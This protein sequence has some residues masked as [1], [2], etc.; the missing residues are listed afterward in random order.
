[1]LKYLGG[2][3]LVVAAVPASAGPIT[4]D[5]ITTSGNAIFTSVAS[6]GFTFTGGHFHIINDPASIP[7]VGN[8]T[9]YLTAEAIPGFGQPVDFAKTGGGVFSLNS[10][11]IAE[12]WLPGN[13]QNNFLSVVFTGTL[14]GGGTL[15]QSFVLDGIR[16]GN[17]GLP[18][19]QTVNFV[20]WNNLISVNITG[21][22][23]AGAFGDYS[24][25]NIVVNA[26]GGVPE[27]ATWAM[28]LMG[29]GAIGGAL[30]RRQNLATRIRFA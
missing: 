15:N 21:R 18:D 28:M 22:N 16:D 13:S 19:F 7:A 12:L 4:F 14:S 23:A 26:T 11:D 20:G 24:V 17:G 2:I 8:G 3:A 6:G 10:A 1:M 9:Q 27:P 25:D 29:L 30:R 5:D